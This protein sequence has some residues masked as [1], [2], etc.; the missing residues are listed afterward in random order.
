MAVERVIIIGGGIA[1]IASALSRLR[2]Q[3]PKF[4]VSFTV[5]EIRDTP[6]T[7]GG[8]INLTSNALRY[9]EHLGVLL[10]L[11]SRGAPV[12]QIEI[13][14]QRNGAKLGVMSFDNVQRFKH[15][16]MRIQRGELLNA[17]LETA[18]EAGIHI[19]YGKKAVETNLPE[20][21]GG[22]SGDGVKVRFED[23]EI[24]EGDLL[25]GCD[26]IHSYVR[27]AVEHDRRPIYSGIATAYGLFDD[28]DGLEEELPFDTTALWSGR[29]GSLMC[30]WVN[31]TKTRTYV[32]AVMETKEVTSREG[33]KV[34]GEDY[35][36]VKAD[37]MDRFKT[38]AVPYLKKLVDG[39]DNFFLYPVFKLPPRGRWSSGCAILLGDAAHAMPPQGE[40]IGLAIEDTILFTRVLE[41]YH[42]EPLTKTF[43]MYERLRKPRIDA[44]FE[45]AEF[46]WENVRDVGFVVCYLREWMTT[47]YCWWVKKA[48]ENKFAYDVRN[49]ALED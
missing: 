12:S 2:E 18:K 36:S 25:L 19:K 26:G 14:S 33:W 8:A 27:T 23:G 49:I 11:Q 41:K 43:E 48:Y 5:Y 24:A 10:K 35:E 29:R 13:F 22:K 3:N 42:S 21:Q 9:L 40:S 32:A 38:P 1:G 6:S 16:A 7:I 44:A 37:I 17:M 31:P 46:R 15:Q 30:S 28:K 45:E 34:K 4:S 20:E 47:L 39:V